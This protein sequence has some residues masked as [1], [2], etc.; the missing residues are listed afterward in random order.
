MFS[1]TFCERRERERDDGMI[2]EGKW[3]RETNEIREATM[4]NSF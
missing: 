4:N 2:K 1:I 3:E